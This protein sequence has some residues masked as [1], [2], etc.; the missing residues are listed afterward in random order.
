M[1]GTL[2]DLPARVA[3][4]GFKAPTLTIVGEVVGLRDKLAWFEPNQ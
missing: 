4:A 3:E 1:T 2:A